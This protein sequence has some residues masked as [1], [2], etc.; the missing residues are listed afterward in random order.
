[1]T[2]DQRPQVVHRALPRPTAGSG[3]AAERVC[4]FSGLRLMSTASYRGACF[5]S[6][7]WRARVLSLAPEPVKC[8]LSLALRRKSAC[9]HSREPPA[10]PGH[11]KGFGTVKINVFK[12]HK[13]IKGIMQMEGVKK[14]RRPEAA[15]NILRE[16][17]GGALLAAGNGRD[18]S[19][20]RDDAQRDH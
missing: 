15:G 17:T 16:L 14:A 1:K 4:G 5:H 8:V 18:A 11:Q 20:A 3:G 6:R 19:E 12:V 7:R 10:S 2:L 9:F 13:C